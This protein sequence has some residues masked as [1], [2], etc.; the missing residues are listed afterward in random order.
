MKILRIASLGSN[1]TNSYKKRVYRKA[2]PNAERRIL[3]VNPSSNIDDVISVVLKSSFFFLQRIFTRTKN[4][5]GKTS[6]FYSDVF[7]RLKSIKK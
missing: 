1:F 5:K 2:T 6:N 7:M 4:I 3:M